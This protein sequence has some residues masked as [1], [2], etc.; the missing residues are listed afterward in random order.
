MKFEMYQSEKNNEWFFR[1]KAANG[2]TL[3]SSEGYTS[4]AGCENGIESVKMNCRVE[5]NYMTQVSSN[6]QWYWTLRAANNQVIGTSQ[7]YSSEQACRTGMMAMM[8]VETTTPVVVMEK[9]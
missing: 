3:C 6:N 4:K 5:D 8:N 1:V 7:M 9:V 2:E